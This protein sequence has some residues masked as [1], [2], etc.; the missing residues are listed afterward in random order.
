MGWKGIVALPAR[1]LHQNSCPPQQRLSSPHWRQGRDQPRHQIGAPRP[2]GAVSPPL[3]REGLRWPRL[4]RKPFLWPVLSRDRPQLLR[5][6]NLC[7]L[8]AYLAEESSSN[9]MGA[10]SDERDL[11]EVSSSP[12]LSVASSAPLQMLPA[13]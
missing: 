4:E 5:T 12:A 9:S 1:V 3:L 7:W 11:Q 6:M 8:G 13:H 2:T 10:E